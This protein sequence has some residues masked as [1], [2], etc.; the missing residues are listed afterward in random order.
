MNLETSFTRNRLLQK[1]QSRGCPYNIYGD[2]FERVLHVVY[3][4]ANFHILQQPGKWESR[5]KGLDSLLGESPE[6]TGSS[7][8]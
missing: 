1:D 4:K 2:N 5:T 3:A 6:A 8:E 7:P